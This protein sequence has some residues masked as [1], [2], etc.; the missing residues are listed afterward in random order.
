MGNS[1]MR[2]RKKFRSLLGVVT[3]GLTDLHAFSRYTEIQRESEMSHDFQCTT[4]SKSHLKSL[5]LKGSLF[6]FFLGESE[7][8]HKH[9]CKR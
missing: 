7:C 8:I 3:L 4:I 6:S 5:G 2:N 1:P 9:S